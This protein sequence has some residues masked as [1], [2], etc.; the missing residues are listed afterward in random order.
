MP[1]RRQA[2]PCGRRLHRAYYTRKPRGGPDDLPGASRSRFSFCCQCDGCRKRVTRPSVRCLGRRVYLGAVVIL[3]A[4][5]LSGSLGVAPIYMLF[6]LLGARH[7]YDEQEELRGMVESKLRKYIV[8][9]TL[10]S[11][12]TGVAVWTVLAIFGVPLTLLMGQLTFLLN[13]IPN[14]GPLVTCLLLLPLIWL[15]PDLSLGS[16]IAASVLSCGVQLVSG[17]V[18]ETRMIGSSFEL[19]RIVVLLA[20]MV[21]FAIWGVVGMLLAVPIT[22]ALKVILQRIERSEPIARVLA[23]DLGVLTL[24][25]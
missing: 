24:G 6:L 25:G 14:F 7:S 21:W 17:N 5:A 12:G 11:I 20:L 16:M 1:A 2:C 15:S 18:I 3:I 13:Y 23:G 10:I 9:K 19:H 4:A 8:L 22:A